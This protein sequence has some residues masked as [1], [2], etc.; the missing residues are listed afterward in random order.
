MKVGHPNLRVGPGQT[1]LCTSLL[2]SPIT[3]QINLL[4]TTLPTNPISC[5]IN[6]EDIKRLQL[7]PLFIAGLRFPRI[8]HFTAIHPILTTVKCHG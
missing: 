1:N 5:C 6:K 4:N 3:N 8:F 7:Q 2:T